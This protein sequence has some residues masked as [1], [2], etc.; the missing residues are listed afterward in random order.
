MN[1]IPTFEELQA[2]DGHG[3]ATK[4]EMQRLGGMWS[5][6]SP[7]V[8]TEPGVTREIVVRPAGEAAALVREMIDDT[9]LN[10]SLYELAR[11]GVPADDPRVDN[12]LQNSPAYTRREATAAT[13]TLAMVRSTNVI[14]TI[15]VGARFSHK[16]LVF[17]TDMVYTCTP[18]RVNTVNDRLLT[19]RT[20]NTWVFTF[21]AIAEGV[22][23]DY[24]VKAGAEFEWEGSTAEYVSIYA[25]SDA[26]GARDAE[27]T[28]ELLLRMDDYISVPGM[29]GR[30]NIESLLRRQFPFVLDVS[31]IGGGD[32]EMQRDSRNIMNIKTGGRVDAYIRTS[33]TSSNLKVV[34]DA[35]R[36]NGDEITVHIGKNVYPGFYAVRSVRR[37]D[38]T[39]ADAAMTVTNR[40][41]GMDTTG[42]DY[43]IPLLPRVTD[44]RFTRFQT[45]DIYFSDP[46]FRD[47]DQYVVELAGMPGIGE[48]QDFVSLR[49]IRAPNDDMLVKAPIPFHIVATSTVNYYPGTPNV[50]AD[51]IRKVILT[52]IGNRY[53]QDGGLSTLH[54]GSEVNRSLAAGAEVAPPMEIY[55]AV[56]MPD[57]TVRTYRS[58]DVLNPPVEYSLGVS[59]RTVAFLPFDASVT[60]Q[61]IKGTQV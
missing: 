31:L 58:V 52:T 51:D 9:R 46:R 50:N 11:S 20:D 30:I 39:E 61:Q 48:I 43:L 53:F 55:G 37:A 14:M 25:A 27:T 28:A 44:A 42:F 7:E 23:E 29:A 21:T 33:R 18:I 15:P 40:V 3:E 17:Y 16:G 35:E 49:S 4:E 60:L 13:V 41:W 10:W 54:I 47:G 45:L 26:A 5:A 32:P 2:K 8:D 22:G 19:Q 36:V 57:G 1:E 34:L 56:D 12:I 6:S 24:H 59:G 38:S